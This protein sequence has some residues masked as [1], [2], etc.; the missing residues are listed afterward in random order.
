LSNFL[1]I[2][3]TSNWHLPLAHANCRQSFII[4]NLV[5]K[6]PRAL[7]VELRHRGILSAHVSAL[8]LLVKQKAP[9]RTNGLDCNTPEVSKE[10]FACYISS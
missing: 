2:G 3:S 5:V 4:K 6:L 10:T 7:L 1:C 9:L 8:K